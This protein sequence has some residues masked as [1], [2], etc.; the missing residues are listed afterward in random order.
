MT[1]YLIHE[2]SKDAMVSVTHNM[3]AL[4]AGRRWNPLDRLLAKIAKY[5]YNHSLL[6]AFLTGTIRIKFPFKSAIYIDLPIKNKLDFFGVNYYTRV[7]IRFNP[8]KKMCV[9]LRHE[10]LMDMVLL[11][12]DGR[13]IRMDSKKCSGILQSLICQR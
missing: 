12:W 7:H 9:E 1:Y 4:V 8:F 11:I 6:D 2:K 5:F 3:A 10:I 13:H